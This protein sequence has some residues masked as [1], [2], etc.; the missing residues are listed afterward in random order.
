MEKQAVG[1]LT[2]SRQAFYYLLAG[3]MKVASILGLEDPFLGL[4]ADEIDTQLE[5]TRQTLVD[6]GYLKVQPD[7]SVVL[8]NSVASLAE[9]AASAGHTLI[10]SHANPDAP[11]RLRLI[12]LASELIVEQEILPNG[13][14]V[15]TAV[16]DWEAL[17]QRLE[18]FFNVPESLAAPGFPLTLTEAEFAET[19]RLALVGE[20]EACHAFLNHLGI[21]D[22]IAE[23]LASVMAEGQNAGSLS[24]LHR[25]AKGMY[26]EK[27]LAWLTGTHGAWR[28]QLL[29][30]LERGQPTDVRLIPASTAEI[31]QCLAD[32]VS[33]LR[34]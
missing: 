2:L 11:S 6:R 9:A 18:G 26:Y 17:W 3:Q 15:L 33:A 13:E 20:I 32:M 30:P 8:D 10:V 4:A 25:E 34:H 22:E 5:R 29:E 23:V 24:V 1:S 16:S 14:V 19:R 21:P 28:M 31:Q 7:G 27:S 12:H